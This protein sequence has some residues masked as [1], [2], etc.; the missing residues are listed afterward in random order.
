M[1]KTEENFINKAKSI[2]GTKNVWTDR[3]KTLAYGTDASFYRYVPKAIVK[4]ESEKQ[5]MELLKIAEETNVSLTFRAAGTS[6]SGQTITES[7]IILIPR[8][9][10]KTYHFNIKENTIKA[11]PGLRGGELNLILKKHKRQLGADPAS[12]NSAMLGGIVANNASGMRSG[13]H[14]NSYNLLNSIRIVLADGTVLDNSDKVSIEQFRKDKKEL[15]KEIQKIKEKI[16]SKPELVEKINQK[17]KIKN[18]IGYGL[19]SFVDFEDPVDIIA[20]LMI[21]SEGTLGFISEVGLKT[22]PFEESTAS[23]LLLFENLE[24]ACEAA[25]LLNKLGAAAIELIDRKALK[26]VESNEG[27]PE[28]IKS[29]DEEVTALLVEFTDE[30]ADG[31]HAKVKQ[32]IEALGVFKA[33]H[34]FSFSTD[35]KEI[36]RLWNVRKGV[37]PAVGGNRKPGSTVFI[38]DVA[39]NLE[40][41]PGALRELRSMLDKYDYSDAVIYGHANDGNVHFIFSEDM[42]KKENVVRYTQFMDELAAVVVDKYNG[43]L[44]AEHGTGRNM[45]PFVQKEWG[46]ELYDVHRKIKQLFDPKGILNPGVIIN[47]DQQV[48]IKNIKHMP[49][50]DPL[51]DQC[52]ECGFC[53][54]NC[55]TNEL[56][57]S[58][59]QRIVIFRELQNNASANKEL[60]Q[61]YQKL[62]VDTCAGDSLCSLSCP[63]GIDTGKL[64]KKIR[65]SEVN[66]FQKRIAATIASNM[67]LTLQG[68]KAGLG[69]SNIASKVVGFNGMKFINKLSG[70]TIPEWHV[71]MPKANH[72]IQLN[73]KKQAQLNK[74][75]YFPSCISQT[76]GT[77]IKSAEKETQTDVVIKV[78][79]RAGFEIVFPEKRINS[80]VE[81]P[82]KAR[83]ILI[84]PIKSRRSWK[85]LY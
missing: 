70:G 57:M 76:M 2:C 73:G 26:A 18:T 24:D 40:K 59:R 12:I 50:T 38:E 4:A 69:M 85:M 37:F 6:L 55:L 82:G 75:V 41:L 8:E 74:V 13:V 33:V 77:A 46:D 45:A 25:V 17:Y 34:P 29:L 30:D 54:V 43:S 28:I 3:L 21:G 72:K 42:R 9:N 64:V 47:D 11:Q 80:A 61:A 5:I 63:V 35:K 32:T 49:V 39:F 7:V 23:G 60:K 81:L 62:G 65:G 84:L 66:G 44:K 16:I 52:I 14:L 51:V 71:F 1:L 15:I 10:W 19:N 36:A 27:I 67:S 78:L 68:V 79:E 56:N 48:H 31:L 22:V 83:G 20:H 58:A 53:E